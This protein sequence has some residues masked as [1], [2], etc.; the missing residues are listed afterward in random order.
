MKKP[1]LLKPVITEKVDRLTRK[2]EPKKYCFWVDLDANKIQIRAAVEQAFN[3][4][5]ESVRTVVVGANL[6]K[7]YTRTG[8][9]EGKTAR[10]K[11]AY[12]TLAK[13]QFIELETGA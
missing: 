10:M 8:V 6:R 9:L 11:K 4:E 1:V 5:V 2:S 7:R 13:N 12:I 3:V